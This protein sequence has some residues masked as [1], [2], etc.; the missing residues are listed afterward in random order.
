MEK[1]VLS[2]V[3]VNQI[4]A[5]LTTKPFQEV[6]QFI[7]DVHKEAQQ[8]EPTNGNQVHTEGN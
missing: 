8:Q 7:N 2:T 3:L 6:H 5:Y 1:L 4:L